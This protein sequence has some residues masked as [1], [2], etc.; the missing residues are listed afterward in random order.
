MSSEMPVWAVIPAAGSGRRMRAAVAKQYLSFNGKTLL[1]HCLDRLLSHPAIDGAVLVLGVDDE[2][3][4]QLGY[5]PGKPLLTAIGGAERQDSVYAG[6]LALERHCG[7]AVA[8]VHDAVRPL[9][10]HEDLGRVI[11]AVLG[12]EA[13][14]I[15]ASPVTDTLKR[16]DAD[17]RIEAT[18]AREGLWRALTPQAFRLALLMDALRRVIDEGIAVTDDAQAVEMAGYS[19]LLVEGS[20]DNIKITT[21]GDL[22]LAEGIWLDQRDQQHDE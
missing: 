1:E 9:V 21:P 3:W 16:Q 15:L 6:L 17:M 11:D 19:P 12:N 10:S 4:Q 22:Q 13:G 2:H 5:K 18:V 7:D 20:A 8:L 14:A